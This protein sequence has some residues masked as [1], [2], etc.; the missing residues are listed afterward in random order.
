MSSTSFPT[1]TGGT[2]FKCLFLQTMHN[3]DL[4][5]SQVTKDLEFW[6]H[7]FLSSAPVEGTSLS[8]SF[9]RASPP[10]PS[11]YFPRIFLPQYSHRSFPSILAS[12]IAPGVRTDGRVPHVALSSV[13]LWARTRA[14]LKECHYLPSSLLVSPFFSG[15]SFSVLH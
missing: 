12:M 7:R 14:A 9:N 15:R 8:R 2:Q 6:C 1:I 10:K 3:L 4:G 5:K 13:F 11:T